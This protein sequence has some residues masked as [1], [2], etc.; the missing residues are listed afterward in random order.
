MRKPTGTI[1]I[2]IYSHPEFYPPTL[3]S[4]NELSKI[5]KKIIVYSR[6]V[7]ASDWEYPQNVE[8]IVS[9]TYV[10][11]RDSETQT[12]YK[13]IS[14]FLTYTNGFRKLIYSENPD[15]VQ[16]CDAI[17]L[18]CLSLMRLPNWNKNFKLWYHSHDVLDKKLIRKFSISWIASLT[19]NNAFKRINIFTLPAEE[20]KKYF[21]LDLFKG[22]YYYL[23]NFP[24]IFFY[25]QFYKEKEINQKQLNLIFQGSIG[26]GHGIENII[27]I[28]NTSVNGYSLYLHLKGF[29]TETYKSEL[30]KIAENSNTVE[31][32]IFHGVTSYKKVPEIAS[33]CHVG[34]GIHVK[35]DIMN[36]TL[37][38]SSN[39]LY[40]YAAL[41]LP[42]LLYDNDHFRTHFQDFE[43]AYF[44]DLSSESI[45]NSLKR[46]IEKYNTLSLSAHNDFINKL[47]YEKY[48]STLKF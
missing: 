20:R 14:S 26:D 45:L 22:K 15:W 47:N 37:G 28:L 44:T 6:N 27:P 31:K 9:G 33:Y 5:F 25:N 41:G 46:I 11:I 12:L 4:I 19:Q 36:Q 40:E 8:L 1:I 42:V 7:L 21:P 34:I 13:K 3:N 30:L 39:K 43:W 10:S 24:S 16:V 38:T 35:D 18:A 29:I 17:P 2:A 23:P 32:I 48:F